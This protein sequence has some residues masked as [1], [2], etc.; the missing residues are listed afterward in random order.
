MKMPDFEL[1]TGFDEERLEMLEMMLGSR[2]RVFQAVKKLIVDF[3]SAVSE[4]QSLLDVDDFY[5]ASRKL[6]TLKGCSADIGANDVSTFA[7]EIEDMIKREDVGN[8]NQKM[9]QLSQAWQVIETTV[10]TL[11]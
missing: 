5:T 1:L 8:I 10:K 2:M 6:H 7:Y 11:L 3:S 4:I 9:G